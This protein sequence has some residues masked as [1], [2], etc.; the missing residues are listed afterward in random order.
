MKYI[1]NLLSSI[2]FLRKKFPRLQTHWK[3]ELR[4][5]IAKSILWII[6][7]KG[8]LYSNDRGVKMSN[9]VG[10]TWHPL[11]SWQEIYIELRK[12]I[13]F[14]FS[15]H[16]NNES[17]FKDWVKGMLEY[18]EICLR[19]ICKGDLT[20][21]AEERVKE[22]TDMREKISNVPIEQLKDWLYEDAKQWQKTAGLAEQLEV[23]G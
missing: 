9:L 20:R 3:Q 2:T 1:L 23:R 21:V 12:G 18:E 15:E 5:R 11:D 4:H 19:M 13:L 8:I 17:L 7:E 14:D 16:S 10:Q 6:K 22:L